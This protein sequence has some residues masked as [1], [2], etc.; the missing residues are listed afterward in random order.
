MLQM[1][2]HYNKLL[3]ENLSPLAEKDLSLGHMDGGHMTSL[4]NPYC[5]FQW[6]SQQAQEVLQ[7]EALSP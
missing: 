3:D 1:V 4:A 5:K 6:A 2:Y 7:A